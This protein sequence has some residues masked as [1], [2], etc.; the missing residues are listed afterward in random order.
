MTHGARA[1][2]LRLLPRYLRRP[3]LDP[4]QMIA[5]NRSVLAF[6]LIWL[7]DAVDRLAAGYDALENL[8]TT[9]P[10]VGRTFTFDALP[11]AMRWLQGGES[12]GKVVVTT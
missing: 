8:V 1:N 3:R 2:Y 7:W 6:N 9:S 12:V 11:Q 5:E 4:V 10:C